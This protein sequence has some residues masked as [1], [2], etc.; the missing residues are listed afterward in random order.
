MAMKSWLDKQAGDHPIN[1]P[2]P[3]RLIDVGDA[4]I[5]LVDTATLLAEDQRY[6]ALSYRWGDTNILLTTTDSIRDRMTDI[7]PD[8]MPKTIRDAVTA[9]RRLGLR[10][11]WVDCLCII[12]GDEDDWKREAAGMG[13]VYMNAHC[14][15]STHAAKHADDGFLAETLQRERVYACGG[16]ADGELFQDE[17]TAY[18]KFVDS[19]EDTDPPF[20]SD[21]FFVSKGSYARH[22][23]DGSEPSSRGWVLQERILSPRLIHF[24]SGG[25]LYF[26]SREGVEHVETGLEA[27]YH[28]VPRLRD[29]LK[30]L[31]QRDTTLTPPDVV[32]H[33]YTDWYEILM[34]FSACSLSKPEDKLVALQGIARKCQELTGDILTDGVWRNASGFCLLWLSQEEPLGR[35]TSTHTPSW[36]WASVEGKIQFPHGTL[37]LDIRN[38]APEVD[39]VGIETGP[40]QKSVLRL[41]NVIRINTHLRFMHGRVGSPWWNNL[42]LVVNLE[43]ATRYWDVHDD[44]GQHLGW[45]SLDHSTRHTVDGLAEGICCMKTASDRNDPIG[46]GIDRGFLALFIVFSS[47]LGA[48]QRVGM[49]QILDR[50]RFQSQAVGMRL[51]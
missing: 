28:P 49:G 29:T 3:T 12:Q 38:I 5:R 43:H 13:D 34:R 27:N 36:S 4:G 16:H 40:S 15:F 23:L 18:N 46:N 21:A 39:L 20:A 25:S 33:V 1:P 42:F 10:Y 35:N 6:A 11:L 2:P 41:A 22:H 32:Q 14:T 51:V 31:D 37:G 17:M 30:R 7:P 45:A 24:G 26:K 8:S 47:Q 9:T 48:W 44:D 19:P 50:R